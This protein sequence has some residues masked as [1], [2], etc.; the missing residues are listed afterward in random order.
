MAAPIAFVELEA[1]QSARGLRLAVAG[2]IPSPWSEAAKGLFRVKGVPHVLVRMMPGDKAVRKWTRARNVPAAMYDDE[3]ARTGWGDI[4][5]LAERLGPDVPLVPTDADAR[6]RLYG[7]SHEI[8]GEG[9]LL[10]SGRLMTI[11]AGLRTGGTQGFPTFVAEYLGPRYGYLAER[12]SVARTRVQQGLALL[13]SA[14]GAGPYYFG[15]TLTALDLYSAAAMN[16]FDPFPEEQCPMLPPIRAAFESMKGEM[17][18][19]PELIAHRQRVYE[20]HLGLPLR[21]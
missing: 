21:L 19:P 12:V 8:M 4:L 14:L 10:W 11:E 18:V 9:G 6:V 1:A 20:A 17:P 15:D 13:T 16:A 3:P 7:L 2:G 5:E